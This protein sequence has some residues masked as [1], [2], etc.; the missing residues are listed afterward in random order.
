MEEDQREQLSLREKEGTK[1]GEEDALKLSQAERDFMMICG[2]SGGGN[3]FA[4]I[5]AAKKQQKAAG[6]K[7]EKG[8]KKNNK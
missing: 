7:P 2:M 4:P 6:D 1:K 8:K 5:V 3:R